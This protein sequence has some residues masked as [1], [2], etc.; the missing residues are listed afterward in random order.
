MSEYLRFFLALAV[1]LWICSPHRKALFCLLWFIF[2]TYV[3]DSSL[4]SNVGLHWSRN[5]TLSRS[6]FSQ[7]HAFTT[8][9]RLS[10]YLG[11]KA[12]LSARLQYLQPILSNR[13]RIVLGDAYSGGN[14]QTVLVDT[15]LP[16]LEIFFMARFTDIS[17]LFLHNLAFVKRSSV[18]FHLQWIV[19]FEHRLL[20]LWQCPL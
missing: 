5:M 7:I 10:F 6:T 8:S 17:T 9:T 18:L 19:P 12:T 20:A 11:V 16:S 3:I 4:P 2:F 15:L 1:S 14:W 13:L